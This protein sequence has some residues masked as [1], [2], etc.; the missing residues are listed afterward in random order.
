[1][2]NIYTSVES[3]IEEVTKQT[4]SNTLIAAA[5]STTV[6]LVGV[7]S[8]LLYNNNGSYLLTKLTVV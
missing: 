3:S 2:G 1:M 4:D 6:V 5:V 7:S 8:Y